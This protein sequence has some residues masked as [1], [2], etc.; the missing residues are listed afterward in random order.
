MMTPM[1]EQPLRR[2]GLKLPDEPSVKWMTAHTV[3][4]EL[5]LR[6][7]SPKNGRFSNIRKRLSAISA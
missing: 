1:L 2:P 3:L 4:I 7:Q 6:P 5:G